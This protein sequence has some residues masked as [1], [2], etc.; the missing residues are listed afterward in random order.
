M[1]EL[2]ITGLSVGLFVPNYR[3]LCDLLGD[4]VRTG[5][6]KVY[7]IRRWERLFRYKREGNGFRIL[8]VLE[9]NSENCPR[10]YRGK[11]VRYIEPVLLDYICRNG[12]DDLLISLTM[13]ELCCVVGL[14]ITN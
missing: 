7:Q 6:A 4:R 13:H 12:G 10:K 2:D 11:Y 5:G 9:N 8:E 1:A 14:A 3:R